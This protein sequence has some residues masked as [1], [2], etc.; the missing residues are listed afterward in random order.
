LTVWFL[1][2]LL[3]CFLHRVDGLLLFESHVGLLEP[4][5]LF[6]NLLE[7]PLLPRIR[8]VALGHLEALAGERHLQF[9]YLS[10]GVEEEQVFKAEFELVLL[11]GSIVAVL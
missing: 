10:V 7:L 2:Q 4:V 1:P 5:L 6:A 8:L 3:E 9:V 11:G